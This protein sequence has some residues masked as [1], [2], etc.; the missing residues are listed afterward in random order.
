MREAGVQTAAREKVQ[1][2]ADWQ[3]LQKTFERLR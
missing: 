3:I 2:Q 1:G